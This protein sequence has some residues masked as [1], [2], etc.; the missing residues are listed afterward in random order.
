MENFRLQA[1]VLAYRESNP[2]SLAPRVVEQ[3]TNNLAFRAVVI[4]HLHAD[5]VSTAARGHHLLGHHFVG[6]SGY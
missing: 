3:G 5:H 1:A 4:P 6:Q 2:A